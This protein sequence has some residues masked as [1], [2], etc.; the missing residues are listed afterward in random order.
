MVPSIVIIP[1]ERAF[2]LTT[3]GT[4]SSRVADPPGFAVLG[5]R[6]EAGLEAKDGWTILSRFAHLHIRDRNGFLSLIATISCRVKN[7]ACEE[8]ADQSRDFGRMRLER[9]VASVEE[10]DG[11]TGNVASE[12][13]GTCW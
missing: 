9:E 7:S 12:R 4:L 1:L 11:R 6:K 3:F 5:C 10:M 13:L 2:L 8:V